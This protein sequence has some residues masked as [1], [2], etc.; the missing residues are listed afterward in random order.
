MTDS[1]PSLISISEKLKSADG[2]IFITPEYN[3]T[4]SAPLKSM[5]DIFG[6]AEFAG[7]PIGVASVSTGILG[8]VRAA[9]SLQQ[10]ILA[11][12]AYPFPKMLLT[13]EVTEQVDEMG[14]VL[15]PVYEKKADTFLMPFLNFVAKLAN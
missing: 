2:I 14:N 5:I 6:S 3:G 7:K 4:I 1:Q 15:S 13:A 10:I 11:I 8:G 9:Q 12:N